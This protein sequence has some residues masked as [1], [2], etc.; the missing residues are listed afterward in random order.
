TMKIG[1]PFSNRGRKSTPSRSMDGGSGAAS[2]ISRTATNSSAAATRAFSFGR[3]MEAS[4][5]KNLDFPIVR[6]SPALVKGI[7]SKLSQRQPP[8]A[9]DRR[10]KMG[11][12]NAFPSP[13]AR[14]PGLMPDRTKPQFAK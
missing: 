11:T 3:R 1:L 8:V 12:E 13:A 7:G 9:N 6:F 14:R 10:N 2:A 5:R 4:S